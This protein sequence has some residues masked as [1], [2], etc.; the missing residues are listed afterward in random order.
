MTIHFNLEQLPDDILDQLQRAIDKDIQA[1]R[2]DRMLVTAEKL[3]RSA[4]NQMHFDVT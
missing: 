2:D 4:P 1:L 3:R